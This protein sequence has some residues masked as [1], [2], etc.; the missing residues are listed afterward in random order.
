MSTAP[1]A[2]PLLPMKPLF[3]DKIWGGQRV[4]R[5]P[6]KNAPGL[7]NI[8]ESWEVAD[9][10]EGQSTVA[11]GPLAG[12]TLG[13]LVERH[14]AAL[15]GTRASAGRFPLLV[16]LVDAGDALSVQ[17]HPGAAYAASHPGTSSK[18]ESW[19]ILQADPDG[20]VL[21]GFVDG[22]TEASFKAAIAEDRADQLL[23]RV[24]VKPGDVLRVAPG[25][26]HAIGRGVLL[27]ECQEPS[28]T[29]FRVYDY[30]RRDAA[31]KTRAL[32]VEQALAVSAFGPQPPAL[33]PTAPS[34][35]GTCLVKSPHYQ[36]HELGLGPT[37]ERSFAV[38]VESAVVFFALQGGATVSAD[39]GGGSAVLHEG[40]TVLCP[41]RK[42]KA[43]VKATAP[44]SRVVAMT[45]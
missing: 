5:L 42:G 4:A 9:L 7:P 2:L 25:T 32:H 3:L 20:Y 41:P 22:V 26:V 13:E 12:R 6:N 43:T 30:G 38:G 39:E 31:G 14:G 29:T 40:G 23:R 19:L 15:C 27:L 33:N 18:D 16:K 36:M 34:E 35:W 45:L 28:D 37:G 8:G 1:Q 17:V 11:S 44:G 10:K 24:P 21:H